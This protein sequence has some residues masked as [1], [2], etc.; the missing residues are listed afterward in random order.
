MAADKKRPG[1]TDFLTVEKYPTSYLGVDKAM[2][3]KRKAL[4]ELYFN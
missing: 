1:I 2:F 4:V 3:L